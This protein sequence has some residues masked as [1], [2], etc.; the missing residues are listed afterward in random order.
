M[1]KVAE[2]VRRQERGA[3]PD[4]GVVSPPTRFLDTTRDPRGTRRT[5]D[6]E[7]DAQRLVLPRYVEHQFLA[8]DECIE[9]P[10]SPPIVGN[11][12]TVQLL[13]FIPP[14]GALP[15]QLGNRPKRL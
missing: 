4:V 5:M 12:Y 2:D 6:C 9:R 15:C 8:S 14:F 7:L 3:A 10:L 13:N 11:R 1:D